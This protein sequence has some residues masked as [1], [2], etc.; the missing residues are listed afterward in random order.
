LIFL[1]AGLEELIEQIS[2]ETLG[3][4]AVDLSFEIAKVGR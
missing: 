2:Q 4:A 3:E 1:S